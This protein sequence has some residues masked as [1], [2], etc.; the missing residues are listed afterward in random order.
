MGRFPSSLSVQERWA[1]ADGNCL[2]QLHHSKD[3]YQCHISL[4]VMQLHATVN[5]V[6]TETV[7]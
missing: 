3:C 1:N 5:K 4:L 2:M 6:A 7:Q